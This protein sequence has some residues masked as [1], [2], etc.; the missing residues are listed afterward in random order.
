MEATITAS[1]IIERSVPQTEKRI[2]MTANAEPGIGG[3]AIAM[4]VAT[5]AIFSTAVTSTGPLLIT[6]STHAME[7]SMIAPFGM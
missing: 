1:G 3:A 6:V 2:G 5:K 7:P 4:I